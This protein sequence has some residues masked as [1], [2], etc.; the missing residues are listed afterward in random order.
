[1]SESATADNN[2]EMQAGF[3]V[4]F[5]A[6]EDYLFI[7]GEDGRVITANPAVIMAMGY[8]L[9]ELSGMDLFRLHPPARREE[10]LQ[11]WQTILSGERDSYAIPLYSKEQKHLPVETRVV[12]GIWQGQ[13]V[14]FCICKDISQISRA[15]ARFSKAFAIS[16]ALMAI[17]KLDSGE[18]IDVNEAFLYSLEYSRDEIIGKTSDKTGILTAEQRLDLLTEFK[19]KGS[20]RDKELTILSKNGRQLHVIA[21]ADILQAYDQQY[22]LSVGVDITG[23]TLAE[24]RLKANEERWSSALE[25]SGDG[26]W[27]W[28]ASTGRV[29]ISREWKKMLGY[30]E[31]EIEDSLEEW[32]I[33]VHPDD[34][35]RTI[36]NLLRHFRALSPIYQSEHRLR[37]KDGSY[38]WVLDRGKIL[39]RDEK[40]N[41]VRVIG[42]HTDITSIKEVQEKLSQTRSQ[43][44]AILDNLPFLAWFK[45]CQGRYMEV[46]SVFAIACGFP[47][48]EIIGKCDLDIW[49]RDVA[50]AYIDDDKEVIAGKKQLNKE[51]RGSNHVN[52]QWFDTFKT[53]VY[54]E[55]G[56]VVGTTGI[57]R[58][59][60]QSRKLQNEII[61]QGNFLKALI[62]AVPDLVFIKD[63]NSVYL[64]CNNAFAHRFI[65]MAEDEIV[66]KTDLDFVKD[67]DLAHWFLQKD[68]EML[69]A[70]ETRMNEESLTMSDSS[71]MEVETLRTPFYNKAGRLMGIIGVSRDITQRKIAQNQLLIKQKMLANISAATNELLVNRDYYQAIANCL[72][73]L[74]EATGV[75][76]V[77]FF[78]NH[79]EG[80]KGYS[81]QIMAWNSGSSS[82]WINNLDLQNLSF[83]QAKAFIEPLQLGQALQKL[84]KDF[85][86]GWIR[87]F[88]ERQCMKSVLVLPIMVDGIFWGFVGFDECKTER[89]WNDDEFAILKAF[90]S[91]ISEAIQR[92]QME[93]KLSQA[94][95]AAESANQAKSLF[96]ANMS[97]EIRTPMN[98][99]LGFLDLLQETDLSGEQRDYVQ[100]A[101]SAS[102]VLLYLLN[103][104]LDFSKIEAGKMRM[105]E[106]CFRP[107]I[108]VEDAVSLQA[109]KAREKGLELH[110]LIKSN[111]PEELL[112]DPARLRQILNN[113][114]SNA[115]KFTHQGEI[116]VTVETLQESEEQIEICFEVCDT[117][118]GIAEEDVAQLF[119]PFT[120]VD[121]ST[122]RQYG[123]TG[124]GLAI[125]S[126]L[127][128]LMDGNISVVSQ[129]GQGTK[130]SFTARFKP[131]LEKCLTTCYEYTEI[132]G[133]RVLIVDDNASNRRIIRTY[134]E[135]ARCQVEE[136]ESGEK[137]VTK[138][139]AIAP[140]EQF[141]AVIV[142]FQM[143][144]MNGYQLAAALKAMPSTREIKLIM[145]TSAAQ[146]DDI[147][148]AQEIGFAGYMS[149][150]VKRDELLKCM[151]LVLGL[152]SAES[153]EDAIVTR[154]TIREN[155][156]P[157]QR[158]FLLV[159]D[160]EMNQK[161]VVKI[162]AKHGMY[163]DLA[164]NGLEA[165]QALQKKE[166][167]IVFMDCQMPEMDGYETTAR[168][169]QREGQERHSI[170]VAMTAN[171]MEGD[172]E[173]CLQAGMDDYIKKPI[174]FALLLHMIDRYT[175]SRSEQ[176]REMPAMLEE[177]LQVFLAEGGLE[178][179]ESREIYEQLWVNLLE[180]ITKMQNALHQG[181]FNLLR[182]LAHQLKG[183]SGTLR[184]QK[185][186]E[187]L[188]NLE[189]RA[190]AQDKESSADILYT[191]SCMLKNKNV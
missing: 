46:N 119:Q 14:I 139:L 74:G 90:A 187:S 130:F 147:D 122:T 81:S 152:K 94:K 97:H 118:I 38:I 166:Y 47:R 150:P 75:D 57:S 11:I 172:R 41:P 34:R 126:E 141:T 98:G 161:I 79:Y 162:L 15:N 7:F 168:I 62:D 71:I 148:R 2:P 170:I 17:T 131:S 167:D 165:L 60:T 86:D 179:K 55:Q 128:H 96:L 114:L 106:I 48:E 157:A 112:G 156:I 111:V 43:L 176:A 132:Q 80:D 155:Q 89:T 40:G 100:E 20:L 87:R 108:A 88:L 159:E 68:R 175:S 59:I 143:P 73:L 188:R 124:L 16:P 169:R 177:S 125:S 121:A 63:I 174:D 180:N 56:Q 26:V 53:P 35:E 76:R 83:E 163:C 91:S 129:L 58:D 32:E 140:A 77:Y 191:I 133:T 178:E 49:P 13:P 8:R 93:Q 185:L 85:E 19:H 183:S 101:R 21:S 67:L 184:I 31:D 182:S 44:R 103:D 69:A 95:E 99:I 10:V 45:D 102:E 145:L 51:E 173:K 54:D 158:K 171:A 23:K 84:V 107:R 153:A 110:T 24:E 42:T 164:S 181:D 113:L 61:E 92:S 5:N 39:S 117:G 22:L 1:M 3:N 115:V 154:Y 64:G 116:L 50:L 123:G 18:C 33:R 82:A 134:L 186:Y 135:D 37:S 149:K 36:D 28:D 30:T 109:P 104:I 25:C 142:D 105:E 12:R 4:L 189:Q 144:G 66:G 137:A 72:A 52:G 6:I 136:C 27:D 70:G 127:V 9:E 120:Q 190:I 29:F 151:A 78:E 138:L 146:Q 160:N 65:G